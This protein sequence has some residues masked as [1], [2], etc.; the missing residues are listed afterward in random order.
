MGGG[1]AGHNGL[2]SITATLGADYR[3]A[4]IG[5][6]HP[7]RPEAVHGYVL[8]DFSKA[9]KDWLVPLLDAIAEAAPYLA[10]DDDAGFM[11]KI[12]VTLNPPVKKPKPETPSPQKKDS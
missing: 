7:G 1:D 6:G 10:K 5:I 8:H 11:N 3:R 9:D 2:R 4:R 12:A